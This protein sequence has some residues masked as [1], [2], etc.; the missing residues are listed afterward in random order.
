MLRG[1]WR[2]Q[3]TVFRNQNY[4]QVGYPLLQELTWRNVTGWNI[5]GCLPSPKERPK[6]PQTRLTAVPMSLL[7][8]N[9]VITQNCLRALWES[10]K[11]T[12][13]IA[14]KATSLILA[15][16]NVRM[17]TSWR[18]S[19]YRRHQ[20]QIEDIVNST[21]RQ[22]FAKVDL[23]SS[24]V[25]KCPSWIKS[26]MVCFCVTLQVHLLLAKNIYFSSVLFL[27]L[28]YKM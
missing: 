15:L 8:Q 4:C 26:T 21:S 19:L 12:Q 16:Y 9:P 18:L 10:F 7:L 1:P 13:N 23:L 5:T 6:K 24:S 20:I 3:N 2:N 27:E 17:T 11:M 28:M 14:V 25:S 22:A